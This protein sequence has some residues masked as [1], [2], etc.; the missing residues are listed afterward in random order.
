MAK[1]PLYYLVNNV[2]NKWFYKNSKFLYIYAFG[3]ED[4]DIADE[5]GE[6]SVKIAAVDKETH[7]YEWMYE[8]I[9]WIFDAVEVDI[10]RFEF[11]SS[12]EAKLHLL[13]Q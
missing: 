3:V 8:K 10:D 1:T 7:K 12:I 6:Y 9:S 2:K 13:K 5:H 11:L 4:E